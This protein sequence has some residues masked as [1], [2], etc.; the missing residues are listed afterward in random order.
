MRSGLGQHDCHGGARHAGLPG[1]DFSEQRARPGRPLRWRR[2][3]GARCASLSVIRPVPNAGRMA[4]RL[5]E[6]PTGPSC[7]APVGGCAPRPGREWP[8]RG[9]R[10]V[11]DTDASSWPRRASRPTGGAG[12]RCAAWKTGRVCSFA[13]R[14]PLR[15]GRKGVLSAH[16]P[17]HDLTSPNPVRGSSPGGWLDADHSITWMLCLA[18]ICLSMSGHTVTLTSPRCAFR[19][20]NIWVRDWPMPPPIERGSMPL[21][22]SR[23]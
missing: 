15:V 11:A 16:E 19:S 20:S 14:E 18:H 23:W 7:G 6:R 17:E 2:P 8:R 4:R 12:T 1:V 13:G 21:L 10:R 5:G 22:I 3:R 9:R